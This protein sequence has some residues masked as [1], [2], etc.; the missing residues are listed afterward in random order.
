[1]FTVTHLMGA[2]LVQSNPKCR[3]CH[4]QSSKKVIIRE[5]KE[6]LGISEGKPT[7]IS[8]NKDQDFENTQCNK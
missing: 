1:M 4:L 5:R 7:H 8:G 6:I 3:L 2:V